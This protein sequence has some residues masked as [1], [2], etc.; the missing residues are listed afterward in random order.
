VPSLLLSALKA[1]VY[2]TS[3]ATLVSLGN[4]RDPMVLLLY[5]V[6]YLLLSSCFP[7]NKRLN[8]LAIPIAMIIVVV[9]S[10]AVWNI[11]ALPEATDARVQL[12]SIFT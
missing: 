1:V 12:L 2:R 3:P 9:V 8:Q 5:S 11:F 10:V 4:L 6:F 7:S